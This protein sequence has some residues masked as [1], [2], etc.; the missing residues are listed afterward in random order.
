MTSRSFNLLV[1]GNAEPIVNKPAVINAPEGV[2]ECKKDKTAGLGR[3]GATAGVID[4]S[5]GEAPTQ[6]TSEYDNSSSNVPSSTTPQ[7]IE[8][9]A[10]IREER[11]KCDENGETVQAAARGR[12]RQRTIPASGAGRGA[13][14]T[15]ASPAKIE[16]R[17]VDSTADNAGSAAGRLSR[18]M[19][20]NEAGQAPGNVRYRVPL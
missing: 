1:G 11:K 3:E 16:G 6:K 18:K 4:T 8:Q 10:A 13:T 9:R 17:A 19:L 14:K 20:T 7:A 2:G 5:R 12:D 15:T